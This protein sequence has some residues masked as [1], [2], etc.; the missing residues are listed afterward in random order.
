MYEGAD[1]KFTLYEDE[2]TN[3]NYEKGAFVKIPVSYDN[4]TSTLTIGDQQGSFP[5]SLRKRTFN[6]VK[7]SPTS[8][9]GFS[10]DAKGQSVTYTGKETRIRL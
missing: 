4:A 7:V 5:G 3:Y 6:V 1:G 9:A 2:N 8:P 10:R